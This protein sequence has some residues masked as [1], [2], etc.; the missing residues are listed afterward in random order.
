MISLT[1]VVFGWDLTF[2]DPGV[3]PVDVIKYLA[4]KRYFLTRLQLRKQ[5]VVTVT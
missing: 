5:K 2:G 4:K 3:V 1:S